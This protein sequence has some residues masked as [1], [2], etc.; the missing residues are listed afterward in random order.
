MRRQPPSR[1][2]FGARPGAAAPTVPRDTQTTTCSPAFFN[3]VCRSTGQRTLTPPLCQCIQLRLQAGLRTVSKLARKCKSP[4]PCPEQRAVA[5][6]FGTPPPLHCRSARRAFGLRREKQHN[7]LHLAASRFYCWQITRP[8]LHAS[9]AGR[10]VTSTW[11]LTLGGEAGMAGSELPADL[12]P[13]SVLRQRF[14]TA[15]QPAA[16]RAAA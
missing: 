2:D 5:S 10:P 9:V 14:R 11:A 4:G 12:T 13:P 6:N 15:V 8:S 3:C 1:L 7:F 16:K